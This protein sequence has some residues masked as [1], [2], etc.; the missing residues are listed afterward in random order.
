MLV[1]P[2]GLPEWVAAV[3]GAL[4]LAGTGLLSPRDTLAAV[5][6]GNDVYLFLGG[7]MLLSEVA[8]RAGLFDWVAAHAVR[9]ARGSRL[10]LFALVYAACVAVTVVLSN[11][12]TAVVLT[13]AV[14]AAV[15]R[16]RVPPLPY[17]Y[18]CA[19]VANAAS[20]VLPISNPANLVVFARDLPALGTWFAFFGLPSVAAIVATYAALYACAR[21]Q[22]AG[23]LTGEVA[24]PRLARAGRIALAG[25]A[26]TAFALLVAAT[27][28]AALG[29]TT[30]LGALGVFACIAAT[31]RRSVGRT[32]GG[33]SWSVIA[34]VAGLFVLVAGV[35]RTGL[36]GFTRHAVASLGHEPKWFAI[37]AAG[38]ASALLSNVTNNLPSGLLAGLTLASA[39]HAHALASAVA[40][41]IDLGPNLS[42]TGSLATVLW[43]V[44]LRREGIAVGTLAFLRVGAIVMPAALLPALAGLYVTAR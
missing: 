23:T 37:F 36:L 11:D 8:R 40:I 5:A 12:A 15:R 2:R 41:G 22:L 9:A 1:R 3:A 29:M 38:S 4:A 28:R 6:R 24:A 18:A 30:A 26:A 21:S 14:A 34:L 7:M 13:P 43:L 39:P 35:D 32:L 25:I 16:T 19:F 20:F 10:R 42:V 17:L 33:V 27:L 44:A 31:D